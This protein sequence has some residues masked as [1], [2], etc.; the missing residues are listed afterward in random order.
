MSACVSAAEAQIKTIHTL[1]AEFHQQ[2]Q[3]H[4]K[5][6]VRD[7]ERAFE[8]SWYIRGLVLALALL[9]VTLH[10]NARAELL[11]ELNL[12]QQ[13]G[14]LGSV[15]VIIARQ[16]VVQQTQPLQIQ[17]PARNMSA[18]TYKTKCRNYSRNIA[19]HQSSKLL[20]AQKQLASKKT[21]IVHGGLGAVHAKCERGVR[22]RVR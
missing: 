9:V 7:G 3:L 8:K 12:A 6:Q 17:V 18:C 5:V 4:K 16:H 21:L 1:D 19:G 15:E 14:R 20:C 13:L 11:A 10:L 2:K 22:L